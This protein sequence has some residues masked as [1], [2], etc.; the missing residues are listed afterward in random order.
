MEEEDLSWGT[1]QECQGQIVET[2]YAWTPEGLLRRETDHSDRSTI[3]SILV[4]T[5]G[6]EDSWH[7]AGR[8]DLPPF[9]GWVQI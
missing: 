5:T 6:I 1:P 4:D 9:E 8:D 3:T 2:S 7:P